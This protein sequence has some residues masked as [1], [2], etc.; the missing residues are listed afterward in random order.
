MSEWSPSVRINVWERMAWERDW[1]WEMRTKT[2]M[3][4]RNKVLLSYSSTE[5]ILSV[6]RWGWVEGIRGIEV[7]PFL[8][9][10][11]GP[12]KPTKLSF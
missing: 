6:L 4:Y 12:L 10:L 9:R 1:P 11:A 3:H 2:V 8:A 5:W 7:G